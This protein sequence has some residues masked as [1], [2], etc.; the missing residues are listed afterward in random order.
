MNGEDPILVSKY[1]DA[2]LSMLRL[3]DMWIACRSYMTSGKLF[4]WK[5]ELDSV[6]LELY[7]DVERQPNANEL[8][9]EN[10]ELMKNIAEAKSRSQL[11]FALYKR[12]EFLRGLQDI[13]GKA[14]VYDDPN[15]EDFE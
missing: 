6:W 9:K 2:Q 8:K 7:I 15:N 5:R 1:N 13:A 14:G 10:F 12:H 3:N 11:Y 4:R